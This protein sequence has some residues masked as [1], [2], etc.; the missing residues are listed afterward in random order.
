MVVRIDHDVKP[1]VGIIT[2]YPGVFQA[3]PDPDP[4]KTHTRTQGRGFV[5]LGSGFLRSAGSTTG[6]RVGVRVSLAHF[7]LA[8]LFRSLVQS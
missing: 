7:S 2:G 5:G 8:D 1:H 4:T 3:D 6:I